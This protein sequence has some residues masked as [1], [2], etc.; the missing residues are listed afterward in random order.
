MTIIW[1]SG[2]NYYIEFGDIRVDLNRDEYVISS[3]DVDGNIK[4][5]KTISTD[6]NLSEICDIGN[7]KICIIGNSWAESFEY[8][9]QEIII[10]SSENENLRGIILALNYDGSL[11]WSKV[12]ESE[13]NVRLEALKFTSE[14]NILIRWKP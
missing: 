4:W 13:D 5:V 1:N 11:D 12:V 6:I 9:N 8:E 10:S 2:E 7:G 3:C 14:G